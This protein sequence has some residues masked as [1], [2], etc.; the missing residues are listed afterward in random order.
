MN[1]ED[2]SRDPKSRRGSSTGADGVGDDDPT[3]EQSMGLRHSRHECR[4]VG[5]TWSSDPDDCHFC[6]EEVRTGPIDDKTRAER[7]PDR[8]QKSNVIGE[9]FVFLCNYFG[10]RCHV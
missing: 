10:F 2:G 3:R 7:C 1:S 8:A 6:K 4:V 5:A 9:Y